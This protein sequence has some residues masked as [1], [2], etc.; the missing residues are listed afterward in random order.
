[1]AKKIFLYNTL[2]RKLEEFTP[3]DPSEVGV[4]TCGPTVYSYAHIG[5]LRAYLFSD[6]LR[7]TLEFAGYNIKHVM[8]ITDV[9]HLTTDQDEGDDKLELAAAKTGRSA[10]ELATYFTTQFFADTDA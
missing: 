3:R 7:R 9:G 8:N 2:G 6:V 5:N 10:G 1:M 4:Y